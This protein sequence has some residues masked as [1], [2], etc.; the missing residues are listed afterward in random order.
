MDKF[1]SIYTKLLNQFFIL[2]E[3]MIRNLSGKLGQKLRAFYYSKRAGSCGKNLRIDEGVI[4]QGIKDIY[5]GDNV[6]IDKY[7]IVTAGKVS[8]LTDEN[9]RNKTKSYHG[10]YNVKEGELRIG[11]NVHF[12]PYCLIQ[13][14][15]GIY[16]G[17][18]VGLA[19]GVKLYSLSNLPNDPTN[20][21]RII[22]MTSSLE[23]E[24]YLMSKIIIENNVV[25]SLNSIV[26]PGIIIEKNSFIAPNS[27][28]MTK[29]KENSFMSGNPAKRIKDRFSEYEK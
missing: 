21:S 23:N 24:Y 10:E 27:V 13:A 4:I 6:W 7:C 3:S 8:G 22:H 14:H 20:K 11:N 9:C 29:V 15:G 12:T 18:H 19:S 25:I 1:K 17:N 5:F 2:I 16:I 26:L 28:V